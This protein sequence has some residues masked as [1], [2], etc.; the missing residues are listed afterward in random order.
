MLREIEFRGKRLDNKEWVYGNLVIE[1]GFCGGVVKCN[2]YIVKPK[3]VGQSIGL[4]GENKEKIYEGDILRIDCYSYY[5]TVTS[6]FGV[7]G[8]GAY[9]NG[10]ELYENGRAFGFRYLG[11]M[12]GSYSTTYTVFGNIHD[13]PELIKE[14]E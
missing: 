1:D 3:T 4:C 7:V 11:E 6:H 9:G 8:I 10:L 12:R 14:V 2:G 5:E 13:N